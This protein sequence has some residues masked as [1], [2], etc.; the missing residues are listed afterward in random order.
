MMYKCI[1]IPG[2]NDVYLLGILLALLLVWLYFHFFGKPDPKGEGNNTQNEN[3]DP[4]NPGDYSNLL[5]DNPNVI[6]PIDT[7]RVIVDPEDPGRRRVFSDKVN[8]A[9]N[10]GVN[11]LS[12]AQKL[13]DQYAEDLKIVYCDTV[14]KLMQV[15]T[16]W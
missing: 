8:I 12:F 16:R 7:T 4:T 1:E 5:P 11:A 13:H 15:E 9:L 3:N 14:I 10:K 6:P 2:M